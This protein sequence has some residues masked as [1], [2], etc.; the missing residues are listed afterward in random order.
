MG[1]K[2]YMFFFKKQTNKFDQVFF[3]F[4]SMYLIL[5]LCF[6]VDIELAS[7]LISRTKRKSCNKTDNVD[8]VSHT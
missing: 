8:L 3:G 6:F 2:L 1:K 4:K 7:Q 5:Y